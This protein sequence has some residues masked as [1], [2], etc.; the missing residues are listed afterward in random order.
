[1]R[2][3]IENYQV[4]GEAV[5]VTHA[6]AKIAEA[7]HATPTNLLHLF[8]SYIRWNAGMYIYGWILR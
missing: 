6:N 3:V 7:M 1:M 4:Q 2:N 8:R 5:T